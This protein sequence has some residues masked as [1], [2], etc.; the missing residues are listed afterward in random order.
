ML[1]SPFFLFTEA[2]LFL[3]DFRIWKINSP[4]RVVR[5][6]AFASLVAAMLLALAATASA[7]TNG[8][9]TGA[10]ASISMENN[11]WR[12]ISST[13]TL[14]FPP[15]CPGPRN[16]ANRKSSPWGEE[17]LLPAKTA[18][19]TPAVCTTESVMLPWN[20]AA[21]SREGLGQVAM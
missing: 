21:T 8:T 18:Q 15:C 10:S 6:C 4:F 11:R 20:A 2:R 3:F 13:S 16:S 14:I 5:A 1:S 17:G 7:Q 9:W 19:A 12:T